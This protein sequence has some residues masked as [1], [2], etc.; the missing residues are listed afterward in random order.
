MDTEIKRIL[1]IITQSEMGGAQ[2]FLY[3][4]L[5]RLN[6]KKYEMLVAAG[7]Q[8]KTTNYPLL[9]ALEQ[10]NIET[11]R[12][13]YLKRD[14]NLWKDLLAALE[15]RRLIKSWQPDVLFLNSSKAGFLS[16]FVSKFLIQ[17]PELSVLYRIGG[18]SFNDPWP[19][20]KKYLWI[21]LEKLSAKWKDY[22]ILNNQHDLEQA[23]QL[24][25]SPRKSLELIHNGIDVFKTKFL[26]Q[27][28]ARLKLFEKIAKH[29]GKIFQAKNVVGTIANLYPAKNLAN[30]IAAAEQFKS[31]D[32]IVFLAIGE[33]QERPVLE[34][35]IAERKLEKKVFLLGQIPEASQFL[36]AFDIFVLP[37]SKEGFPWSVLEAMSAKIPVIATSVGAV[38]EIIED[39]KNGFLVNPS[40]PNEIA[41]R[42]RE[43]L[44]ND[45]L[46]QE[47]GI[48]GHQ[49]VLFK[50]SLDKMVQGIEKLLNLEVDLPS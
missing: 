37:S 23:K 49:T 29:S 33:G 19:K 43:I 46:R 8:N 21:F 26:P 11:Y 22:I 36:T 28:E 13:N 40:S 5:T 7:P 39:G 15:I 35:I 41:A 2:R 38:P 18:W 25:I 10:E 27:A 32:S 4:F 20:W 16:S 6:K 34:K 24:N 30:F 17:K 12:L 44:S 50:F 45:R 42:V 9:E 31:D 1:F 14:I 3:T 48:Q 47:L